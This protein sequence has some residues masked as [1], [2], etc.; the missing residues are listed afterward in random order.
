MFVVNKILPATVVLV[1]S[2][3][4]LDVDVDVLL[5]SGRLGVACVSLFDKEKMSTM[6]RFSQWI[7]VL[8]SPSHNS[9]FQSLGFVTYLKAIPQK[10]SS[11]S[12][13]AWDAIHFWLEN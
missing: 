7:V 9:Y 6:L 4:E 1:V 3:V 8:L 5:S 13:D 10:M 2:S 11:G 12:Q